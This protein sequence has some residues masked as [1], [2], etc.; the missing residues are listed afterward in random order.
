M[1]LVLWRVLFGL[2]LKESKTEIRKSIA[3]IK[4][5]DDVFLLI[6]VA[7]GTE[8]GRSKEWEKFE[9][10]ELLAFRIC[11]QGVDRKTGAKEG[12]HASHLVNF[13]TG[14]LQKNS[15]YIERSRL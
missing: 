7:M 14:A 9:K 8:K 13:V 12:A 6:V 1:G 15:K 3:I 10:V 5:R 11:L 4:S 2:R